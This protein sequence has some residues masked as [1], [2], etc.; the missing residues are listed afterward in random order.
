MTI[1]TEGRHECRLAVS[2]EIF[3]AEMEFKD[4]TVT[5]LFRAVRDRL[6][7]D[8]PLSRATIGHLRSGHRKNVRPSVAREIEKALGVRRGS[9]FETRVS[10]VQ[11]EVAREAGFAHVGLLLFGLAVATMALVGVAWVVDQAAVI[12]TYAEQAGQWLGGLSLASV[13]VSPHMILQRLNVKQAAE[14]AQ[15]SEWTIYQALESATLHGTQRV[16]GGRWSIRP[17]CLDAWLDNRPCEHQS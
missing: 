15:R 4:F 14:I 9:L 12:A 2:H 7:K 11:R 6:P 13:V 16:K 17:G 5:T 3:A 8:V 1:R 10:N